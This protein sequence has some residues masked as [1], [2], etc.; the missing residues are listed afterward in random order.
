MLRWLA[1]ATKSIVNCSEH[2]DFP[3]ESCMHLINLLPQLFTTSQRCHLE[4]QKATE[5]LYLLMFNVILYLIFIKIN[6]I[7]LDSM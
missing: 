2:I 5:R 4:M 3:V 1:G 6:I 7:I